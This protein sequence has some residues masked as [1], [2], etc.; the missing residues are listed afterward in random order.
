[1]KDDDAY[2]LRQIEARRTNSISRLKTSLKLL[3]AEYCRSMRAA[4]DA[5]EALM[6]HVAGD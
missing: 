4:H 1:M 5:T 6:Q 2:L 3:S